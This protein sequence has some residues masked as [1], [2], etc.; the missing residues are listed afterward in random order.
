MKYLLDLLLWVLNMFSPSDPSPTPEPTPTPTPPHS[1]P[2][3]KPIL[4]YQ[5]LKA[6]N[7]ARAAMNVAPLNLCNCLNDA[8]Y[9]HAAWMASRRKLSHIGV[10]FSSSSYRIKEEGYLASHTGENIAFGY[11]TVEEVMNGWLK[12]NGHRNNILSNHYQECGFGMVDNYWCAVFAT[13]STNLIS[14]TFLPQPSESG[15]LSAE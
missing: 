4:N 6:H 15:P 10:R 14:E 8:A 7:D 11:K 12:S 2:D 13:P 1:D 9:K 3:T 5:L